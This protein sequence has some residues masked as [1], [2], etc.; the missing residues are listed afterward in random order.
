MSNYSSFIKRKYNVQDMVEKMATTEK[1]YHRAEDECYYPV[2]DKQTET[3]DVTIRFLPGKEETDAPYIIR[4]SHMFKGD[5]GKW[6]IMDV[7]PTSNGEKCPVCEI[8]SKMWNTEEPKKQEIVRQ[9]KRRKNY[10]FNILVVKDSEQPEKEGKVFPFMCGSQIFNMIVENMKPQF[11]EEPKNPFDLFEGNN[12]H[13]R[14]MRDPSSKQITYKKSKFDE[15]KTAI[16][17]GDETKLEEVYNS[18]I[19]L[20]K[21]IKGSVQDY[22]KRIRDAYSICC[23][24]AFRGETSISRQPEYHEESTKEDF[25]IQEE[26][27]KST[28]KTADKSDDI[29]SELAFFEELASK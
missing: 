8:N 17:D 18:M 9:R 2:M 5:N 7:C 25:N 27:Q 16:F 19:D 22:S 20:K 10:F 6:F 15:K 28:S 26:I 13:L 1:K 29:D 21:F 3:A 12:F 11:G 23:P 4:Y 24:E 14:I